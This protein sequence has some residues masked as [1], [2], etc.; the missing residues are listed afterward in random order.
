MHGKITFWDTKSGEALLTL[1]HSTTVSA[2]KAIG[3]EFLASSTY[4][5][6]IIFIWHL[7][8]A[9]IHR[10][11][12]GHKQYGIWSLEALDNG[13]LVRSWSVQN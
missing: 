13:L 8:S 3:K 7:P 2:L 4:D 6:G 1:C 10:N 12:T 11:L 5:D 9:T